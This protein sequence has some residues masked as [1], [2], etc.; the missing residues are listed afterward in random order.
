MKAKAHEE[1]PRGENFN[2]T[3]K[4]GRRFTYPD[5]NMYKKK[6]KGER[7]EG[8]ST[9]ALPKKTSGDQGENIFLELE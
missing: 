2:A 7:I 6:E 5:A 8:H 1:K 9:N 3:K 4:N